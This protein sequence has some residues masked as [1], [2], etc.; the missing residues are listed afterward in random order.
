MTDVIQ[1]SVVDTRMEGK[2]N[3]AATGEEDRRMSPVGLHCLSLWVREV[4]QPTGRKGG[5]GKE[6]NGTIVGTM[7]RKGEGLLFPKDLP[8][9]V[10][11]RRDGREIRGL[12][13]GS[14]KGDARG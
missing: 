12:R 7:T 9:V 14:R 10:V 1:P 13:Q 11:Y 8:E 5:T 4:V 6:V 3:P 2:K